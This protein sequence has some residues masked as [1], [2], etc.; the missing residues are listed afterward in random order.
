MPSVAA[1]S[2]SS[3]LKPSAVALS[4]APQYFGTG[5]VFVLLGMATW[6]PPPSQ[7]PTLRA[8]C[9]THSRVRLAPQALA[10][11]ANSSQDENEFTARPACFQSGAPLSMMSM[12]CLVDG[13]LSAISKG[14]MSVLM[15]TFLRASPASSRAWL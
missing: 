12:H 2:F 1:V 14:V 13:F 11:L 6:S 10:A 5:F 8:F 7:V 9:S 4:S 3:I 15:Y